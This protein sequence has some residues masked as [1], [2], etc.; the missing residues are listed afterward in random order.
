MHASRCK[1]VPPHIIR[2]SNR[3]NA[4]RKQSSFRSDMYINQCLGDV[5]VTFYIGG[6][7]SDLWAKWHIAVDCAVESIEGLIDFWFQ[8]EW[9]SYLKRMIF[10]SLVKPTP[11]IESPC[12][13]KQFVLDWVLD[14]TIIPQY[15]WLCVCL[16]SLFTL[17]VTSTPHSIPSCPKWWLN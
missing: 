2:I 13:G 7:W 9:E 4:A 5:N 8:N 16:A 15:N 1:L 10:L 17:I 6:G 11:F 12:T 3:F 14:F